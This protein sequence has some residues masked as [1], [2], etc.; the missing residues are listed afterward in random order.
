MTAFKIMILFVVILLTGCSQDH[1]IRRQE[2]VVTR[3]SSPLRNELDVKVISQER[4]GF[5]LVS[6]MKNIAFVR[7]S[8]KLE[9]LYLHGSEG[10]KDIMAF[11]GTAIG[12]GGCFGGFGYAR[13]ADCLYGEDE[14]V[15]EGC[16][17]SFVSALLGSAMVSEANSQGSE[18]TKIMPGFV[19]RDTICVDSIILIKQ[20]IKI[21]AEN[22][23]FE[24]VYY[25]D[26]YGKI[27]IKINEIF[28][29]ATQSDSIINLIIRYYEIVD[30]VK[31]KGL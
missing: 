6:Q 14:K 26:E 9:E 29:E 28:P 7:D 23:D 17:M 21:M 18:F 12:F 20:K 30:T 25:T 27:D 11:S 5:S 4:N 31:V 1:F 8:L 19:K 16:M 24:K 15:I 3:E 10:N 13:S 2:E 22:S